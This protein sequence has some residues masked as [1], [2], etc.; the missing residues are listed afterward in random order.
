MR[1]AEKSRINL[2]YPRGERLARSGKTE[3][4]ART[5]IPGANLHPGKK[6]LALNLIYQAILEIYSP[7]E[8]K[9]KDLL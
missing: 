2:N 3:K 5:I 8:T 7:L 1:C 9:N 6:W 4:K